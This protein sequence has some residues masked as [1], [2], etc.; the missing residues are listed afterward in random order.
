[1]SK[2]ILVNGARGRIG[3]AVT[4][5]LSKGIFELVALNDP[6]GIDKLVL[7]LSRKDPIHELY[8]WKVEK[9]SQDTIAINGTPIKVYAEK[10]ISKI[11]FQDQGIWLVEECSGYFEDARLKE[12]QAK[13]DGLERSFLKQ[14][15]EK[16]ILSYRSSKADITLICGANHQEYNSA[17]QR[18]IS[19]GSCAT[20]ALAAPL[21]ILD[22]QGMIIHAVLANSIQSTTNADNVLESLG[23]IKTFKTGAAKATGEIIKSLEGKMDGISFKVPTK[24]GSFT[25]FIFVASVYGNQKSEFATAEKINKL[26]KKYA[27]KPEYMGRLGF[28]DG[29]EV[30]TNSD[31]VGR[32][33]NAVIITSKT[34]VFCFED[35]EEKSR[36]LIGLVS[37]FDNE[38]APPRDQVLLTEYIISV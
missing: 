7:S 1:M 31:I 3:R 14:G 4:Y 10:D 8:D 18:I 37:G 5:E 28:Y 27:S 34:R 12:K 6:V 29:K 25:N 15:V 11:P 16:V 35:D 19:N 17:T 33:E 32:T 21:K 38:A 13:E 20:K 22:D 26:L 30:S 9:I 36:F 23:Q 2:R 24:D